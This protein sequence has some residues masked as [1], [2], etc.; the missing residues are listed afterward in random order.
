MK[1]SLNFG[2][3]LIDAMKYYLQ[4]NDSFNNRRLLIYSS[5]SNAGSLCHKTAFCEKKYKNFITEYVATMTK[6]IETIINRAADKNLSIHDINLKKYI[7]ECLKDIK[8][9]L[10]S[11]DSVNLDEN[12]VTVWSDV[13]KKI[14]AYFQNYAIQC[15]SEKFER[16]NGKTKKTYSKINHCNSCY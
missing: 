5:E 6:T 8:I 15:V 14:C 3:D 9:L 11:A 1:G 12:E 4:Q 2:N 7:K 13:I 10:R 16:D